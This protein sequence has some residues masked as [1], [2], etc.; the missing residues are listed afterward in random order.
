MPHHVVQVTRTYRLARF[1]LFTA[2]P[3][4]ALLCVRCHTRSAFTRPGRSLALL[5]P[6]VLL[7]STLV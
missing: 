5:M 6:A 1:S 2:T 3:R 7:L 4:H